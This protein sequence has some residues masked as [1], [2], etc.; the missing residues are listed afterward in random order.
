LLDV[1]ASASVKKALLQTL[2][3][4]VRVSSRSHIE[5]T[6]RVPLMPVRNMSAVVVSRQQNPNRLPTVEP[7]PISLALLKARRQ[8]SPIPWPPRRTEYRRDARTPRK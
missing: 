2:I 1:E 5:P 4:D 7:P 6:F 3:E 8:R